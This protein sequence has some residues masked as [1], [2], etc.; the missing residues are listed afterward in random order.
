MDIKGAT[1]DLVLNESD[2][3]AALRNA[4]YVVDDREFP[5]RAQKRKFKDFGDERVK[6]VMIPSK[7]TAV[8]GR[9]YTITTIGRCAFAGFTNVDHY[10][11]PSTITAIEDYAFFRSSV[12]T[13]VIPA[14]VTQLGN[15]VFGWC[16]KLRNLTLPLGITVAPDL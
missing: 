15:R 10:V 6:T 9:E 14:S 13:I 8:D 16:P 5:M 1:F 2:M 3:T 11:I 12:E 4:K 7:F